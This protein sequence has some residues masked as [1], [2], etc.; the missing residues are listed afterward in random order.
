[1]LSGLENLAN[2]RLVRVGNTKDPSVH[3]D[4]DD[5][6]ND[7]HD[8]DG[9]DD[10]DGDGDDEHN[11]TEGATKPH[12]TTA[13]GTHITA[14]L[15]LGCPRGVRDPTHLTQHGAVVLFGPVALGL[16]RTRECVVRDHLECTNQSIGE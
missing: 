5:V 14:F 10:D 7:N 12:P 8:D 2:R 13:A 1:M 15:W 3:D 16:L 6:V 11:N 9:D 4:D